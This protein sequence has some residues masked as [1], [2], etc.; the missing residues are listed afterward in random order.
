MRISVFYDHVRQAGE[1]TG[2]SVEE[3]LKRAKG[4]GINA[5]ECSLESLLENPESTKKMFEKCG[6]AVSSIYARSQF[7]ASD[8]YKAALPL[9]DTAK[10]F[11]ADKVLIIPGLMEIDEHEL[12]KAVMTTG[13]EAMKK[14]AEELKKLLVY[15]SNNNITV[16]MEDFDDAHAPFASD[17]QLLWFVNEVKGLRICF[18]TGNFMYAAVDE[19][20]A[21]EKL[22]GFISHVHCKDRRLSG[23]PEDERKTAIDGR[24][25]YPAPVG[26]GLIHIEE[27]VK[28]LLASGYD[29][30]FA[31]EH[32]G[33][34]DQLGYMEQSAKWLIKNGVRQ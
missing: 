22:K 12:Q 32:F 19:L 29:G 24:I 25:M 13:N 21:F 3:V 26:Y 10:Y 9:I 5:L 18:D 31:I 27:I 15:A 16:T 14:I 2:L 1:Q 20:K 11:G 30:T 34:F 23:F 4:F 17:E 7:A 33:A 28:K 6:I 8:T